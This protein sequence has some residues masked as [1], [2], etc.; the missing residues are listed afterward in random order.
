MIKKW[1]VEDFTLVPERYKEPNSILIGKVI[2]AGGDIPG[3][4]VWEEPS[5]RVTTKG[6]E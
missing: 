2:R 1:K 5:L 6:G 3:I 4:R